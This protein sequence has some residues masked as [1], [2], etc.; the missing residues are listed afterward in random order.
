VILKN[1][2]IKIFKMNIK[3]NFTK[4]CDH[5]LFS[6]NKN[7][8]LQKNELLKKI[9]SDKINKKNNE[10]LYNINLSELLTFNY[11]YEIKDNQS[12]TKLIEKNYYKINI[13]NGVCEEF[14]DENIKII[15]LSNLN[16][17]KTFDN[18]FKFFDDIIFDLNFLFL[19]SGYVLTVKQNTDIKIKLSNQTDNNLTIFQRNSIDCKIGSKVKIIEE[20]NYTDNTRNN[21]LNFIKAEEKANI[22]HNILQK[23]K[24]N[25]IL[26][27]TSYT[28]CNKYAFYQQRVFNF[29]DG[30]VRNFHF[31]NLIGI[32]SNA[33]FK[34]CSFLKDNNMASNKTYIK[35]KSECCI[36]NQ[37]YKVILNDDSKCNYFSN[38]YV[39]KNAQKTEGY[40]LSKGILLSDNSF[41]F[42]KP[43]LR[44]F[45]D[46]VKC[47]HGST[48]GPI[49]E[50]AMFYLRS[51]GIGKNQAL[52]ILISSF[53]NDEIENLDKYT[54]SIISNNIENYLN[55]IQ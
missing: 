5:L 28:N 13:H 35:H 30:F 40:Q 7:I 24:K 9:S 1:L 41:Y 49:D 31:A 6:K 36:S 44:I 38:T 12:A 15:K 22:E 27:L 34:G 33:S 21:I 45:A 51:R 2:V 17:N 37:V 20:F 46:D 29:S 54:L 8:L 50:R 47:S 19:N 3:E 18:D 55:T 39:D 53:I 25:N 10:S 16:I 48:I 52:K 23:F 26:Y 42:S 32:E 14:E 11:K 43:E 4:K